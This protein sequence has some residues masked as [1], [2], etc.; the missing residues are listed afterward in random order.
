M[1][2]KLIRRIL[3]WCIVAVLVLAAGVAI[4]RSGVWERFG[5]VEEL[6]EWIAGFGAAA[7]VVYFVLQLM[8][9]IIAPIPSNVS[10]AAGA[11]ALGFWPGFLLGASAVVV[12]SLIVF[13][14]AKR[15]GEPFVRRFVNQKTL[16]KYMPVIEKKRDAFMFLALLLP[17]FPDDLLCIL[18]GLSG[19]GTM[20]FFVIALVTRPWGLVVASAVGSG[21]ISMPLWGWALIVLGAVALMIF[22]LKY[23]D[24]LEERLMHKL[25]REKK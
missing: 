20:R 25:M 12:G 24:V 3:I 7:G 2:S 16:Q 11:L 17:F 13:T 18:A 15:L 21:A 14:L 4:Y 5:S 9:V 1:N 6:R 8:T 19:M 22:G 10:T 23:G